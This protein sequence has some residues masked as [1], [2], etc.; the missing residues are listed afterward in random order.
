MYIF[1]GRN[2]LKKPLPPGPTLLSFP[3]PAASPGT[4]VSELSLWLSSMPT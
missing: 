2:V 4:L 1:G 3:K